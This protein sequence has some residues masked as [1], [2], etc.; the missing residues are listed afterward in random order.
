MTVELS[1]HVNHMQQVPDH[2]NDKQNSQWL[3]CLANYGLD[4]SGDL[5]LVTAIS[6]LSPWQ[7]QLSL[8]YCS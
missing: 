4:V 8:C 1:T 6:L 3:A 7:L 2:K 5:L